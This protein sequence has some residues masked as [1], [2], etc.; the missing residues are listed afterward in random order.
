M[1]LEADTLDGLRSLGARAAVLSAVLL[2]R[3]ACARRWGAAR[4]I[5]HACGKGGP[6]EAHR[7][8]PFQA[9]CADAGSVMQTLANY[10]QAQPVPLNTQR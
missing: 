1:H 10:G 6:G 7:L 2:E 8:L 9:T 3:A 4:S 5:I